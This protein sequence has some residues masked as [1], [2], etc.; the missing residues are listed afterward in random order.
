MPDRLVVD[1]SADGQAAVLRWAEGEVPEEV[2]REPLA[3]PL[4]GEA[5]EDLRWYLE[6]YLQAPY[7]VWGERGPAIAD[8]VGGWGE[9]VFTALFSDGPAR[10]AYERARDRGLEVLVRSADADLL[11]LP[12]ELM[13]DPAG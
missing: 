4:D 6:D 11:G 12:W 2:S 13:R 1:L 8:K 10:F 7:G 3:W 5:L 9:Q